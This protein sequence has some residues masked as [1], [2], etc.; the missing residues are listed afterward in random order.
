M[1]RGEEQQDHRRT[2]RDAE[3]SGSASPLYSLIEQAREQT[4]QTRLVL[5]QKS[6]LP[7]ADFIPGYTVQR[8]IY[9]GGQGIVYEAIQHRGRRR[10]ALKVLRD[11]ALAG[12]VEQMRFKREVK[13][14]AQFQHPNIVRLYEGGAVDGKLFYAMDFVD[15]L[16]FDAYLRHTNCSIKDTL[17]LVE[18]IAEAVHAAHLKGFV[19]RDLKPANIR[20]DTSGDPHLLDFGLAKLV[21]GSFDS[22]SG[23]SI[24]VSGQFMGS[25]PWAAPEQVDGS[26]EGVDIRTDVYA[27]GVILFHGLTGQFP[28]EVVG[29]MRGIVDQIVHSK[30]PRPSEVLEAI[31]DDVDT[32]ILKCLNKEPGRRYQSAGEL[33]EDIRHYLRGE[34]IAAKR[35]S[36]WYL[37]R[38]AAKRHQTV[39]IVSTAF[40]L[41]T[42]MYAA[43]MTHLYRRARDSEQES[44]LAA[45]K[46]DLASQELQTVLESFVD[47]ASKKLGRIPGARDVRQELN[48]MAYA[49]LL[50]LNQQQHHSPVLSTT[51]AR[52][53]A[54]LADIA[55]SIGDLQG[56]RQH[57]LRSKEL[58]QQAAA[59]DS[60]DLDLQADYSIALVRQ[61]DIAGL[62]GLSE[63]KAECYRQAMAMDRKL[64]ALAP[65]NRRFLDN[66]AWSCDRVAMLYRVSGQTEEASRL[67]DE[68]LDLGMRLVD[69][70]PE[71]ASA[72]WTK[73]SAYWQR[74]NA[75]QTVSDWRAF[76]VTAEDAL[77]SGRKVLEL[78]PLN[79]NYLERVSRSLAHLCWAYSCN[80]K[81][82][83]A[84]ALAGEAQ[85]GIDRLVALNAIDPAEVSELSTVYAC[86]AQAAA[87][88]GDNET[89]RQAVQE[90]IDVL[91][92]ASRRR[93]GDSGVLAKLSQFTAHKARLALAAADDSTARVHSEKA[94]RLATKA[95]QDPHVDEE[96]LETIAAVLA[97]NPLPEFRDT[98]GAVRAYEQIRSLPGFHRDVSFLEAYARMLA[99]DGQF[100]R[101][102]AIADEGL[103][104]LPEGDGFLRVRLEGIRQTG[105]RSSTNP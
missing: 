34:P 53:T 76:V 38:K 103:A 64:V 24:T 92:E 21:Q 46:A 45:T 63:E 31:D 8:E 83:Q 93:P 87:K 99:A 41:A 86:H 5:E 85:R 59:E 11:G 62:L 51:L 74:V 56:A 23:V 25:L 88:M 96:A 95:M 26:P 79:P 52:S 49:Q 6:S 102:H 42:L 39:A 97:E 72:H 30:P 44:H 100:D 2:E 28:Y 78:E 9:R 35:D 14:L 12:P 101:A 4:E 89:E 71:S 27:L 81:P 1:I 98:A 84:L 18:K 16:P 75:A 36:T 54:L 70:Y 7:Q 67:H 32:I 40:A 29:S 65:E 37:L 57:T 105:S 22:L 10:V 48:E 58:Y 73:F 20:V 50:R 82:E 61:G 91:E 66:L 69:R 47:S 3:V 33:A 80:G 19:H 13:I 77:A 60:A 43:T 94:L 68:M 104:R 55:Q 15:G 90:A 17:R